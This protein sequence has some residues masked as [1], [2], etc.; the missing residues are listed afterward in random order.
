M[1]FSKCVLILNLLEVIYIFL[2]MWSIK[3][4]LS[5]KFFSYEFIILSQNAGFGLVGI[6]LKLVQE[7]FF[8]ELKSDST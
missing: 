5:Y 2:G 3:K 6:N 7:R 8:N 4:T 1:F